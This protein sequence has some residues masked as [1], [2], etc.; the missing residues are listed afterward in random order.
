[1]GRLPNFVIIGA[2]RSGTS[3]LA[4]YLASHPDL[5]MAPRKELHFFNRHYEQGL[6]WYRLRFAEATGEHA[7]GEATPTYIYDRQSIDRMA[8]DI[9]DAKLIAI[10][11]E[12]VS[13]AYSHYW[14]NR[15]RGY[16]PLSFA[17]AI[18]AEAERLDGA[19][20]LT[21]ARFSYVDR[22]RYADQLEYVATRF[23]AE[24]LHVLLV[25]DLKRSPEATYG[26]VCAFLGIDADFRPENLGAPVNAF[27]RARWPKLNQAVKGLPKPLR[28]AVKIIN[29]ADA[30]PYPPIETETRDRLRSEFADSV[31]HLERLL[32]R[33]LDAWR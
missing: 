33:N 2:M 11:R 8:T 25:E 18:A 7:V 9:G 19:D 23:P 27:Y 22:G 30:E 16:E 4:G 6:D 31:A 17:D 10:L 3:S 15:S 26:A 29:K 1:M 5:F 13:R 14:F 12:P 20:A 28:T 24:Q 32:D 21:R